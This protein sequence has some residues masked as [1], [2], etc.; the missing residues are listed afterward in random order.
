MGRVTSAQEAIAAIKPGSVI[1]LGESCSEPQTLVEALIEDRERLKDSRIVEC[2][3][4]PW[5]ERAPIHDYFHVITLHVTSDSREWVR[6]GRNSFLPVKLSEAYALFQ[7]GG[8]VNIDVALVQVSPPDAQGDCSFGVSVGFTMD[9]ALSAGMIIAEVNDRMPRTFGPGQLH[10]DSFDYQVKT[11]RRIV[12]YPSPQIGEVEK[13]VGRNVSQLIGD[14]AVISPG[15]GAISEAILASLGGKHNLGIHAGMVTD[16]IVALTKEK[17]VANQQK[18]I[19]KGKTVTGIAMGTDELLYQLMHENPAV[20]VHPFSYTHNVRVIAQLDN[21]VALNSAV[22]VDLTGQVNAESIGN[23]QLSTIGGQADFVRGAGLSK[24]GKSIIALASTTQNGKI[25]K[26]VPYLK[27]GGAVST[28]RYDN[29]YIVTEY[30]VADLWGKTLSQR[31]EALISIAHPR[32]RDELY[33]ASRN[34]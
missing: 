21:F 33:Q 32:F 24:G 3:R 30:G 19:E 17:V 8:P 13:E 6:L 34:P 26:I 15:I 23:L 4:A 1:F 22:E 7:P 5:A 14:G 28:P 10:V 31:R 25:S 2:R 9:A 11:S 29:H 18:N 20:E 27:E 16:G 12:Q